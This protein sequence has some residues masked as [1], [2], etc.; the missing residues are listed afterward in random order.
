MEKP[1]EELDA[2]TWTKSNAI[3][4]N[5]FFQVIYTVLLWP[6]VGISM[7]SI[8]VFDSGPDD[9]LFPY[10]FV[11]SIWSYPIWMGIFCFVSWLYYSCSE[12]GKSMLFSLMPIL[13][14]VFL[15]VCLYFMVTF[16]L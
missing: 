12:Y 10:A 11:G 4:T 14:G 2:Q 9:R 1:N 7:L 3:I 16:E 5:I 8:M 13:F 15:C 6:W